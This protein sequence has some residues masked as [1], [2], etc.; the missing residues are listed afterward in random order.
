MPVSKE[1]LGRVQDFLKG[2][3]D[4]KRENMKRLLV[5]QGVMAAGLIGWVAYRNFGKGK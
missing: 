3:E 5:T 4:E 1:D 2:I